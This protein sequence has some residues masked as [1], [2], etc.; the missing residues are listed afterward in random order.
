MCGGWF[1]R[2]PGGGG[3][4]GGGGGGGGGCHPSQVFKTSE[5]QFCSY[6]YL[7][8]NHVKTKICLRTCFH[9]N[10]NYEQQVRL[11]SKFR[12]KL[13]ELSLSGYGSKQTPSQVNKQ[14]HHG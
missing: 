14:L 10:L 1:G 4:G 13:K 11:F 8:V 5:L 6:M 2:G 9:Y 7:T 12:I 3:V